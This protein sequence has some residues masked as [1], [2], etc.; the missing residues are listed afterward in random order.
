[1]WMAAWDKSELLALS[2]FERLRPLEGRASARPFR[3]RLDAGLSP[4][5]GRDNSEKSPALPTEAVKKLNYLIYGI[6]FN[7]VGRSVFRVLGVVAMNDF[8][9]FFFSTRG[10]SG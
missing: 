3:L 7:E 10:R 9:S 8:L 1:M 4:R 6:G 5:P 2:P